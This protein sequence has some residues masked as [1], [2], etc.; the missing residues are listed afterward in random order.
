MSSSSRRPPESRVVELLQ[1]ENL[2]KA[3]AVRTLAALYRGFIKAWA[4][5]HLPARLRKRVHSSSVVQETLLR[6]HAHAEQFVGTVPA[7]FEGYLLRVAK[8]V[9]LDLSR[10]HHAKRRNMDRDLRLADLQ[11]AEFWQAVQTS[12]IDVSNSSRKSATEQDDPSHRIQRALLELPK[13]Y[14]YVIRSHFELG[15]TIKQLAA[16]LD[17]TEGAV[18][19][20]LRRAIARLK[21][22]LNDQNG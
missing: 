15:L 5:N 18:R 6:V 1:S 19:E 22:R 13:H 14:Q 20:L 3:E 4:H 8:N 12:A 10:F 17:C 21:T 7:Q 16:N 2:E 9:I 11:S